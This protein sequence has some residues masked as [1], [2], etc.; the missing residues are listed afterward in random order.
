MKWLKL[1][2]LAGLILYLILMAI[3]YTM[4][5]QFLYFPPQIYL[6]P[7]A[8]GLQGF[9][10][11]ELRADNGDK[12]TAFWSPPENPTQKVVMFF[13]G[14]GSAVYSNHDIY[15]E[16]A[17][18]GIGVLGVGYSGYPGSEGVP[19][20]RAIERAAEI[21]RDFL[22][23][24]GIR[25]AQIVYFGTSLGSG[26]ASQ[27]A[28]KHP[29]SLLIL[30]AP[31]NSTLDMGRR[32]VPFL[33]VKLLMKDQYRSDKALKTLDIP[34]IWMHGTADRVIPLSQGQ[35]LYDSYEGPKAAHIIQ[36]GQHTNLWGL[37]GRDIVLK[38]LLVGRN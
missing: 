3:V 13:H 21:Q 32:N 14:N 37:G 11:V 12:L 10:E 36:N 8:I 33:P 20:Q 26:V 16:L 18:N 5:R 23:G 1:I 24:Q 22:L 25:P 6:A 15:S 29:P 38:A 27:L 34:I 9:E 35:K 4:Q 19:T 28:K 30:D 2:L 17:A 31:F 7:Q